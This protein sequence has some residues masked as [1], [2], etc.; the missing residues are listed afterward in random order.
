[1][2]VG[3]GRTLRRTL[4]NAGSI[5]VPTSPGNVTLPFGVQTITVTGKGGR[6]N[7]GN[8]GNPGGAGGAGNPGTNGEGGGGGGG[9]YGSVGNPGNA[10]NPGT[11]GVGGPGG[12][13][14]VKGNPGN[15]GSAGNPGTNGTGGGGGVIVTAN[16]IPANTANNS[17]ADTTI[18]I[19]FISFSYPIFIEFLVRCILFSPAFLF[20]FYPFTGT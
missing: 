4:I 16:P 18:F 8:A 9:G 6:G 1:M 3:F 13:A 11:N 2:P 10:G 15:A 5:T 20:V 12:N 17:I 14:G 19:S 7:A